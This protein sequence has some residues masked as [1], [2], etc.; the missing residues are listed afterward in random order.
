MCIHCVQCNSHYFVAASKEFRQKQVK[1]KI[2]EEPKVA[3]D[4]EATKETHELVYF[5]NDLGDIVMKTKQI[6]ECI[7]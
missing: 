1:E 2:S 7:V 6:D 4:A 3:M 5:L